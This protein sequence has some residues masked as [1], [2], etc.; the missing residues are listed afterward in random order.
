MMSMLAPGVVCAQVDAY[1]F[2]GINFNFANPGAR[3][4]G[5]GGA[6]VALA[7]DATASLANPAGL[8]YLD[9]QFSLE[10][11][12]DEEQAPVGQVTQGGVVRTEDQA[13]YL[14]TAEND[15]F[16]VTGESESNRVNYV[17]FVFPVAQRRVGLAVYYSS[18]A[19]LKQE[20]EVGTGLWCVDQGT[21]FTPNAGESCDR[22]TFGSLY[23]PQS[24][25][26][27]IETRLYGGGFG[28]KLSDVFSIGLSAAYVE[29]TFSGS[30]VSD[31]TDNYPD[32][33]VLDLRSEVDD[34]DF[35]YSA[36]ILYRGNVF[37]LGLGYRSETRFPIRSEI[38]NLASSETQREFDGDFLIPERFS[39]GLA[40][41]P[42]D[43]WVIALE[44][45]NLPYSGMPKAMPEQFNT[46]RQQLGVE[47][48]M[49][50][51]QE[52]HVGLEY[53]T[54]SDNKGWSFRVGFWRD[55]THLIYSSQ[56]YPIPAETLRDE[57]QAG[58][59]LL[60]RELELD[61]DHFTAGVGAAFGSV[62]F[63]AAVDYSS[64]A[65]TDFLI[66]GV[67]YF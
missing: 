46:I 61:F 38:V 54:F 9:S 58:A 29:T 42:S 15:P 23:H 8:A 48:S 6:F 33:D 5:I 14:Y 50:D 4:R 19:H 13:G 1:H 25:T 37:G 49:A 53:T 2:T 12:H 66:S 27:D 21:P 34:S 32:Q 35:M 24:V 55:Q 10:F 47:Y 31:P 62:R 26:A 30:S 57:T 16:R 3:A 40:F 43:R 56:G 63:D 51:V 65:G 11:I 64:D 20:Y 39:G 22:S 41:F 44:Y 18:L 52:Y 17:S 60:Y 28:W 59:A 45:V 36:G 7:D 67:V